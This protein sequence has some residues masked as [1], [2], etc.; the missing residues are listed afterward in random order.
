MVGTAEYFIP[1]EI[2]IEEEIAKMEKEIAYHEGF[3]HGVMTKLS[4]E[5]FVANAKPEIV[6]L[7]RKKPADA[8]QKIKSL[9]VG[10]NQLRAEK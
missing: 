8:E 1:I 2:N 6:E 10:I 3:L 9:Q 4:N 5:R 7:E